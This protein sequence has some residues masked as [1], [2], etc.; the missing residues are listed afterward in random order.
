MSDLTVKEG[1]ACE[2]T[3]NVSQSLVGLTPYVTQLSDVITCLRTELN[4]DLPIQH[5]AL[6]LEVY[7]QPGISMQH[8]MNCLDMPQGTVSRNVKLLSSPGRGYEL[9]CAS[10]NDVNR[11]QVVVYPTKKCVNLVEKL[12]QLL[13]VA[14]Q[15]KLTN[16][17]RCVNAN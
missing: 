15:E 3:Q 7:Q 16:V 6:L 11:K 14:R 13:Q 17:C 4:K 5:I 12:C 8:L 1:S 10:Q 2:M 9:L